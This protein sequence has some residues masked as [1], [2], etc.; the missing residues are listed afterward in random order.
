[1]TTRIIFTASMLLLFTVTGCRSFR[2]TFSRTPESMKRSAP[3][4]KNPPKRPAKP[5]KSIRPTRFA[6]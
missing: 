2:N 3:A 1:M 4:K 5:A 6:L